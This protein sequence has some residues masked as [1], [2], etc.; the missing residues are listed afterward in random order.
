M[1]SPMDAML[2]KVSLGAA[3]SS[4]L[5]PVTLLIAYI[6]LAIAYSIF[7][8]IG[9]TPDEIGHVQFF[10][11]VAEHYA[12]P[13]QRL[14]PGNE[15]GEGHQAPLYYLIAGLATSWI[16]A[17][18]LTT[19]RSNPDLS[20][21][22]DGAPNKNA[23]IH[24]EGERLPYTGYV[25]AWHVA[26]LVSVAFGA[27]SVLLAYRLGLL[28][29][30]CDQAL[31]LGLAA[32]VAFNPEFLFVSAAASND[33]LA[34]A[35]GASIV[36]WSAAA[37]AGRTPSV[38][39]SAQLGLLSGLG[40]LA[41]LTL[42]GPIAVAIATLIYSLARARR[43]IIGPILVW[44]AVVT[45]SAGWWFA[46]NYVLY[47]DLVALNVDRAQNPTLAYG[48]PPDLELLRYL[49]A[50]AHDSYV[51]RFGWMNVG[52]SPRILTALTVVEVC[53][54][55][56]FLLQVSASRNRTSTIPTNLPIVGLCLA[57][58][59]TL[60]GAQLVVA[61]GKGPSAYQGRYLFPVASAIAVLF[62]AGIARLTSM[63]PRPLFAL[64]LSAATI[65][66]AV[67]CLVAV[68]MPAYPQP[69]P[70]FPPSKTAHPA[71]SSSVQVGDTFE[72]QGYDLSQGSWRGGGRGS[73][74]L[75]WR[76]SAPANTDYTVFVQLV[77]A[78][79]RLVAQSDGYPAQAR[80]PTSR[81]QAGETILDTHVVNLQQVTPDKYALYVGMYNSSDMRRLP[82]RAADGKL[83]DHWQTEWTVLP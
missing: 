47:G 70:V 39:A 27:I 56:G 79:G 10:R 50:V 33:S 25:L 77:D 82:V 28:A 64:A 80:Y 46:R 19:F 61:A 8:P 71:V 30:S 17:S 4:R 7:V 66:F 76:D 42:V 38:G 37:L 11:Y 3:R 68:I 53:A 59:V 6:A 69:L 32:V 51:A 62:V 44:A 74:T 55:V 41:K 83:S 24:T 2:T 60:V 75:Y 36:L 12:L 78:S 15:V 29:F 54:G 18:D 49:L 43:S 13:V 63:L 22:I 45:A 58:F 35:I 16:D 48:G 5:A 1:A 9:E 31:A 34:V 14:H 21:A 65:G 67:Y 23:M 20:F 72:L 26:R 40:L 52:P 73:V 81:W 57:F